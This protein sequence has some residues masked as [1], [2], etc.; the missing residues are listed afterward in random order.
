MR[1]WTKAI[2][3]PEDAYVVIRGRV[4]ASP[5]APGAGGRKRGKIGVPYGQ[6]GVPYG[7]I[8]VPYGQIGVPYCRIGVPY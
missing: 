8:G 3:I 5:S 4:P 7:Q 6:I 1:Q 2:G